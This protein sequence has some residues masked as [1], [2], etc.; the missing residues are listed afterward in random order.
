M[1]EPV[2]LAELVHQQT[3]GSAG[4][5]VSRIRTPV[6]TAALQAGVVGRGARAATPHCPPAS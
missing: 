4:R 6:G 2:E 1:D 3:P 5:A